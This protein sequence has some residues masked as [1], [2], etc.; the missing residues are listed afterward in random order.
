MAGCVTFRDEPA[1]P[2]LGVGEIEDR[3]PE[4]IKERESWAKAILDAVVAVELEPTA[5]RICAVIAVIEQESGYQADPE[6]A[7]LPK[8]VK[9]GLMAKLAPLGPLA[10]P[11]MKAILEGRSP[12]SEVTFGR[13]IDG[14]K[15]ERDLDRLFRDIAAAYRERL[16][17]TFVV[18]SALAK[19]LGKGALQDL[20]PVTTA[21]SMQVKV[22]FARQLRAFAGLTDAELREKLYTQAGGVAAGTARLLG[23]RVAY[24]DIVYRFADYNSGVYS[25]RNA[26]FQSLVGELTGRTLIFDGDLLAYDQ[27]GDPKRL[28]TETLKA[29]L[30]FGAAHDIRLGSIRRAARKEKSSDFEETSLWEDVRAAW[31]EKTGKSPPYARIPTVTLASPKLATTRSTSWFASSVKRRYLQCRSR[32]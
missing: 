17:G 22:A 27:D 18:A 15:T 5:E 13:R 28:E 11:A 25:S 2:V 10:E 31:Q 16:P 9:A 20:N 29:L 8:V 3:I 6:V 1:R 26:A 23:Y 21:G 30:E 4:R 32:G 12:G 24:D 19:L 14:L 7:N